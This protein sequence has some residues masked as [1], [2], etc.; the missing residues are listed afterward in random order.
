MVAWP[1]RELDIA[2]FSEF[3]AHGRFVKRDRKFRMKPLCQIAQSPTH[4]PMDRRS[5][6]ALHD[7]HKR[8]ALGIVEFGPLAGG[9]PINQ[10]IRA[11]GIEPQ[12][13]VAHDLKT[14]APDTRRIASAATIVN[15]GQR[16]QPAALVRVLGLS[17]QTP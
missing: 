5:R 1:R 12:D 14:Y 3:P 2:K 11:S 6:T 17:R 7:L 9:L 10:P 15:L 8:L 13:P 4:N 16:Q